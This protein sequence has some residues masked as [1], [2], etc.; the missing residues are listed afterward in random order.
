M[1][2]DDNPFANN[3]SRISVCVNGE[4][5]VS[6][7]R[8]WGVVRRLQLANGDEVWL[9]GTEEAVDDAANGLGA[10]YQTDGLILVFE[11]HFTSRVPT[12]VHG[13]VVMELCQFSV[14]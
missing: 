7:T 3:H 6:G 2:P 13:S 1:Y 10:A 5:L 8:T 11:D 12:A 4:W 9:I 14:P